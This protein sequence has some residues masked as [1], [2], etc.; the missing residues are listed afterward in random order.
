MKTILAS[1]ALA[2]VATI[3]PAASIDW[4]VTGMNKV[5]NEYDGTVASGTTVYLVLADATSLASITYDE[6]SNPLTD[7]TFADARSAITIGTVNAGADGKKPSKT[8]NTVS[9]DLLTAGTEY[10]LAAIYFSTASDG[11]GYYRSVV[12]PG[13]AYDP[14]VAGS[15]GAISTS[16]A[17]MSTAQ[18][19]KGYAPAPA[20]P[21]PSSA[22]LALAGLALLLKRRRA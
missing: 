4:S 7:A 15:A 1:L 16:W 10:T 13:T 12:T 8:L 11:N 18:W 6:A 14:T 5:L 9:S 19:T 17:T 22:A 3:A 2:V 20:V 21:E